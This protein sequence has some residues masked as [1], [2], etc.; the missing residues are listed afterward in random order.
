MS[1]RPG[2][3]AL[4]EILCAEDVR[5]I[6]GNPG[7]T[8]GAIMHALEGCPD[9]EYVLVAQE[10]VAMGMADGYARE[11]GKPAFVNLHIETGLSNGLSLLVNAFA[12]GTPLVLTSVNSDM[13]KVAEGR[14]DLVDLTRP[15]T[16]WGAEVTHADHLSA[17][18]RRA[19]RVAKT[20]PTGPTY[21]S[22]AQN[23]LDESTSASISP[24]GELDTRIS[25]DTEL[26][27]SAAR[28]L[29]EAN[30]PVL[31]VGDRVAQ[32]G[33]VD[34]AVAFAEQIGAEVYGASYPEMMFPTTHDQWVGLLPPYV[35][36]YR[37]ALAKADVVVAVGVRVFHDFFRAATDV[38]PEGA[39][40]IQIDIIQDEISRTEVADVG[41]WSDLGLGLSD[42]RT[43]AREQYTPEQQTAVT[44][45]IQRL[46][47]SAA[48]RRRA[49]V[50]TPQSGSS[51]E[52]MPVGL[53]MSGIADALPQNAI[54]VDDSVSSRMDFHAAV[55]FDEN[56]CVHA[57]RAG[58]AIGWG[59][60]AALGVS[61]GA[62]GRPVIAVVGDGSAMM[63]VQALWTAA[64]YRIPI[65]YVICNNA[66]Y[67]V[68]KVNLK[69]WFGEV[70]GDPD[71]QSRYLGMDF[72]NP[73]D[74]A[75]IA[76]SFGVPAERVE[77]ASEV[78][79]AVRRALAVEGPA[80]VD[81]VI[82]GG[83]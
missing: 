79:A 81:V 44:G 29:V 25:A 52:P 15:F 20:P 77:D 9:L 62:P 54:I 35:P 24:S 4:L 42:L 82:D 50:A 13:S 23:A 10:G 72:A 1:N 32:Y 28:M 39:K 40:L 12:G 76:R 60:G 30:H 73:F 57:E 48:D 63:T 18:M 46:S 5:Y 65:V 43:A 53:M 36:F 68:L 2:R 69:R 31:L 41:V 80:L 64:T 58:G 22:I 38:L 56:R 61:L 27:A 66:S 8:E 6:F 11:T 14:T 45:R 55:T 70:L 83:V 71:T 7:T 75:S 16:K 67:R 34:A 59:M 17:V 37:D 3:D 21:V 33:A 47:E 74:F 49:S 51:D 78:A 26:V 19:F